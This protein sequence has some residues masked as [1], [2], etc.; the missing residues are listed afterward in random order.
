[1]TRYALHAGSLR[2]ILGAA[3]ALGLLVGCKHES[4]SRWPKFH[5]GRGTVAFVIPERNRVVVN[6]E[7]IPTIPMEAMVMNYSVDPPSLLQG[8]EPGDRVR[9]R[10]K[11]T[12]KDL[13]VV[14][15][16]KTGHE[17]GAEAGTS[18]PADESPHHHH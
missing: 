15:I 12:Q 10:L 14:A 16:E 5:E 2:Q 7:A 9:F 13:I 3:L 1:M 4:A 18:S 11:E 6:H 8:I 17:A